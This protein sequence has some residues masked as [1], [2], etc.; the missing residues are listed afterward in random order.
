MGK[1]GAEKWLEKH[2][3]LWRTHTNSNSCRKGDDC[4]CVYEGGGAANK[5]SAKGERKKF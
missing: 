2:Y 4:A 1:R 5:L 3:Y